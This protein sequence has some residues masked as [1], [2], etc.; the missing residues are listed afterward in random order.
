[1]SLLE[2]QAIAESAID[3]VDIPRVVECHTYNDYI[4]CETYKGIISQV[5]NEVEG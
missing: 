1:L 3:K 4:S 5:D 2:A